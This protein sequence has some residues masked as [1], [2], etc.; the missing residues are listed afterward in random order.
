MFENIRNGVIKFP[1]YLS[2]E[3]IDLMSKL[4]IKDPQ[5]RLGANGS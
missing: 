2:T 4:M 3:A 5:K 1:E